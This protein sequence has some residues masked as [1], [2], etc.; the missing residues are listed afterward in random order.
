MKRHEP[1]KITYI[2]FFSDRNYSVDLDAED[3]AGAK[4]CAEELITKWTANIVIY[5]D[6]DD[7]EC[8]EPLSR[9]DIYEG[10]ELAWVDIA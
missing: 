9:A 3:L 4:K 1:A 7:Q 6:S 5:A 10:E 8:I 2:A